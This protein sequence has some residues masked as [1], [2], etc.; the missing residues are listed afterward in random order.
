MACSNAH[1]PSAAE[2]TD[3]YILISHADVDGRLG[4]PHTL[5]FWGGSSA[6]A[7]IKSFAASY[8]RALW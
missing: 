2:V 1:L 4:T 3:P 8:N 7:S 5:T 6:E